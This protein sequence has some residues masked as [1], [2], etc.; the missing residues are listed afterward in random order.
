[1]AERIQGAGMVRSGDGRSF[2]VVANP[3]P[4][5]AVVAEDGQSGCRV[6][7]GSCC[8]FGAGNRS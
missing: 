1:M 4:V 3:L 6:S 7:R 5:Q 8:R 2:V